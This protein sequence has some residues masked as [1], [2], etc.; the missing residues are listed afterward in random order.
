VILKSVA[1]VVNT[2]RSTRGR[3]EDA[4]ELVQRSVVAEVREGGDAL[5]WRG[6]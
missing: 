1:D 4:L 6:S 5:A 2:A 3:L